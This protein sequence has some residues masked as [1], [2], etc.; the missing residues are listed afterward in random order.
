MTPTILEKDNELYMTV[1][2][3][4]GATIINSVFETIVNITQFGMNA[5]TAVSLPRFHHQWLPDNIQTENGAIS[6]EVRQQL[7][8]KGYDV[9]D[10][11]PFGKVEVIFVRENSVLEG[12]QIL[13]E[14]IQ[15]LVINYNSDLIK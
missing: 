11:E 7:E 15:L 8:A 1:G 5:Q 2:A 9:V 3:P 6:E 13:E 14:M 10:R 12:G 4:G